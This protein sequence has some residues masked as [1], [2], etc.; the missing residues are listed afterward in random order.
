MI[1][2]FAWIGNL[3]IQ[4]LRYD[5]LVDE[6]SREIA[7]LET[8]SSY[9]KEEF[10]NANEKLKKI[11]EYLTVLTGS[12]QN[13]KAI[14]QEESEAE[15]KREDELT[16]KDKRTFNELKNNKQNFA[17]TNQITQE[18]IKKL[19]KAISLTG[20]NVKRKT[21]KEFDRQVEEISKNHRN[22]LKG[23]GGPIHENPEIDQA[24]AKYQAEEEELIESKLEKAKFIDQVDHLIVLEKLVNAMPLSRPMKNFYVSSGFGKRTDPIT[25]RKALHQGLDF[26]GVT[27]AKI[28]S[29]SKGKVVLA[30]QFSG[31]GNAVVID[32][33]LGITTR[34]GH[35]HSVKVKPGQIVKKG[36]V[37]ALQGNTGRSTGPHL[38]YEVRYKNTPLNPRK[39]LEAG[40][41]LSGKRAVNYV[42]S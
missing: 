28:I 1:L 41:S 17:Q 11:N 2:F 26:V 27:H 25:G 35:L 23:Q 13:V 42:D 3:F 12:S 4:S 38:H 7:K 21:T 20:L 8:S 15:K 5:E 9:F 10:E 32:H 39:F 6:K 31:Y 33:G 37:I 34:Y 16:N 14:E 36:D 29:P 30:G 22:N 24:L 18:R 19:E 40:D